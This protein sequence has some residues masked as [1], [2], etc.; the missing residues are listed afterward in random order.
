MK[1]ELIKLSEGHPDRCENTPCPYQKVEETPYCPRCGGPK[2]AKDQEKKRIRT[3]H[4]AKFQ[5]RLD[6]FVVD[7]NVKSL[8]EEIGICR[9]ILEE[10]LNLCQS[11]MDMIVQSH[12]ISDLCMKIEKLVSSC[13]RIEKSM[14]QY[15]D[16]NQIIQLGLE[17][18]QIIGDEIT[19][20]DLIGRI[21][22]RFTTVIER[23]IHE[24]QDE[25]D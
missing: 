10:K 24:S 21:T 3:Y 2:I 17:I 25:A 14:G 7:P 8:R 12:A 1:Y 18:S 11:S 5:A 23:M 6:D 16:K 15:L 9:I 13:Q 19:D 4:L 22:D 20:A